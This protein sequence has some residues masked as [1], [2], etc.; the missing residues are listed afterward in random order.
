MSEEY[1]ILTERIT[2]L[3]EVIERRERNYRE[4]QQDLEILYAELQ[5]AKLKLQEL[6][7]EGDEDK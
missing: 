7:L 5:A 4:V 3:L 2:R 1:K 6:R